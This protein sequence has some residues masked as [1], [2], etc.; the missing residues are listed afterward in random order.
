MRF[1]SCHAEK[2]ECIEEVALL[3]GFC[4]GD[5]SKSISSTGSSKS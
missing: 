3:N 1:T 4:K 5:Q 2:K